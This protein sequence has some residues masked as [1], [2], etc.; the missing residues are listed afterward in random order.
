MIYFSRL[1]LTFLVVA[2]PYVVN[3]QVAHAELITPKLIDQY[4]KT[5]EER[6]IM[7]E[8]I[9]GSTFGGRVVYITVGKVMGKVY[10]EPSGSNFTWLNIIN[11]YYSGS[12]IISIGFMVNERR[13]IMVKELH[14]GD[15]VEVVYVAIKFNENRWWRFLVSVKKNSDYKSTKLTEEG[16]V[17]W[18][19]LE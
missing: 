10:M 8:T 12:S 9:G 18:E 4:A 15:A 19:G 14:R 11:D 5:P 2:M 13:K 16:T 17:F 6:N 3:S 1:I 7:L